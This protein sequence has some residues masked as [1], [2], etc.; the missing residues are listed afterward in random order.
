MSTATTRLE[1]I[2]RRM[3]EAR[4]KSESIRREITGGQNGGMMASAV[5]TL[6]ICIY[7]L[8]Q[9]PI[10]AQFSLAKMNVSAIDLSQFGR[11]KAGFSIL[12][13]GGAIKQAIILLVA[14]DAVRSLLE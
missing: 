6:L 4:E 3:R 10:M 11:S 13:D 1:D 12:G 7:L 5:I 14:Y 8:Q 2:K 9:D